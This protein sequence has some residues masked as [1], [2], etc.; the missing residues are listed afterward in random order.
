ML[1]GLAAVATTAALLPAG[2]ADAAPRATIGGGSGIVIANNALCTM[3]AVGHD[4]AGRLVG[5][6]AAHCGGVGNTIRSE[7]NRAAGVIGTIVTRSPSLDVAVIR[8]DPS[9]VH[10]VRQVGKARIH[11]VGVYPR[12]L[13][14]VCK[15]GRTTGFTCGPTLVHDGPE[16]LSYVC[17][18]HGDSGGPI[19]VAG[20]LVGMLN[21]AL[22]IAG[23][24]SPSIPCVDPAIPLYSPMIAT[25]M[26]DILRPLNQT[27][28]VGAGF[29]VL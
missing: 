9:R 1:V 10:A 16:T 22:R 13:S 23:P 3:T 27:N 14:N 5:L 20:R 28:F 25:K 18:D 29:R 6:T 8:L 12:P 11:K 7:R 21:G 19:I 4:R 26:T 24:G 2:P 15:A 17:A